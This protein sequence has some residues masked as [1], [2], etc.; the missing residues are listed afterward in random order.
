MATVSVIMTVYNG[1]KYL[2]DATMSILNQTYT[3]FELIMVDDG[4]SDKTS[5]IFE[6]FDDKRIQFIRKEINRGQSY[7][8]NIAIKQSRGEY[9]AIMDADDIAYPNRLKVQYDFLKSKPDISICSSWAQLIDNNSIIFGEKKPP[10]TNEVLKLTLLFYCPIIH[11]T[12]MFRKNDFIENNL[13]YDEHFYYAQDFD[14]WTRAMD[15]LNFYV[16]PEYLIKFRFKHSESISN[17]NVSKQNIYANE[18]IKRNFKDYIGVDY[19]THKNE[20]QKW[21][22][23]KKII[24]SDFLKNN[25]ADKVQFFRKR[26][27]ENNTFSYTIKQ[28]LRSIFIN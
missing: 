17:K 18:I 3:D 8:R 26:F 16:I 14:L 7:S 19:K 2:R 9:I 5:E 24:N 1:E 21:R 11:P 13:W 23:Y 10:P 20:F 22:L 4:S 28:Y 15:K 12:V 27:L 6:S 25:R